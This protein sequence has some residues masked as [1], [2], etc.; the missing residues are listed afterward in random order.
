MVSSDRFH[1]SVRFILG[2]SRRKGRPRLFRKIRKKRT[3]CL[4]IHVYYNYNSI[5]S[6]SGRRS[7]I[8]TAYG[9]ESI[10]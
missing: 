3:S 10:D 2:W 6:V 9:K 7:E 4:I 8:K 5:V 1:G